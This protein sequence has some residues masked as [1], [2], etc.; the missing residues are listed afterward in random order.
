MARG[1][2][3]TTAFL[4]LVGIASCRSGPPVPASRE[5]PRLVLGQV[6][7]AVTLDP[8]GHDHGPTSV[9]LGHFYESLVTFGAEMDLRPALAERWENPTD[10][11]WRLH[12]RR[13]V[14]FHDG[15]P[16]GAED[17]ATSLRRA[18]APASHIRHFV[19]AIAEIHVVNEATVELTTRTP[20]PVLLN[21]LVFV[22][23]V[24]RDTGVETITRPVGT[25]PYRFVGGAPRAT[26]EGARFERYWGVRPAFERVA[27]VPLPDPRERAGAVE[28]GRADVVS[29]Y[30]TEHWNGGRGSS[31]ERLVSRR[32]LMTVMLG[33]SLRPG[34]PMADI[35]VRR[36]IAAA[37]DRDALVRDSMLGL[38]APLDQMVPPSVAGHSSGLEPLRRRVADARRLLAEAGYPQG[39][40]APLSVADVHEDLARGVVSQLG[41]VGV[42][43]KLIV[44]PQNEFYDRWAG[45]ETE[46]T[47]FGWQ[48]STGD[49]SGS[50]DPLLHSPGQ[51]YGRFNHF[52][53]SNPALDDLIELSDRIQAPKER[54]EILARA[55]RLTR[56]DVPVLPLVVRDD[57]Y[58]V[59]TGLDWS[60][61]LD[62]RVRA[63]D[64]KPRAS[65]GASP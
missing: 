60:P 1:S 28:Q 21:N 51:G 61:R 3:A 7:S 48:A 43:L 16:F 13:G 20:A 33:F 22:P 36:A 42:R 56:D 54:G 17:V 27:V 23:I 31:R 49:A 2:S 38:G 34:T 11:T 9:T 4:L 12:L 40:E 47:V 10:T 19:R 52:A 6:T 50:F 64:V 5:G 25:G 29:Q 32:G 14:V 55:A 24:P 63:F 44:V 30:P 26:I 59:G 15:R 65:R 39:F 57:L 53:Y 8:H 58:A 62:R 35:R 37:V 45:E 46:L 18:L 41:E